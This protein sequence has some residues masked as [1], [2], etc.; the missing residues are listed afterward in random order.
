M[1]PGCI[2]MMNSLLP[3]KLRI[4]LTLSLFESTVW[5]VT[6]HIYFTDISYLSALITKGF[7]L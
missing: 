5:N 7:E 3:K 4:P 1:S 6:H 2:V